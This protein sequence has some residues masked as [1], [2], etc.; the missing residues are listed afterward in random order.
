MGAARLSARV[1][2]HT[3]YAT[4]GNFG[5]AEQLQYT[6]VGGALA[7]CDAAL[8]AGPENAL[9]ATQATRALAGERFR[10]EACGDFAPPG[11]AE[12]VALFKVVG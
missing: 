9:V 7:V 5:S 11:S 12:R 3:G 10:F 6:A 4:V 8:V 1:A 2:V